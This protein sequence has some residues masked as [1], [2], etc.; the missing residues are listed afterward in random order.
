MHRPSEE[1]KKTFARHE[2]K[3]TGATVRSVRK[4]RQTGASTQRSAAMPQMEASGNRD[5]HEPMS[6]GRSIHGNKVR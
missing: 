4:S 3:D 5:I 1:D 6:G 2:A